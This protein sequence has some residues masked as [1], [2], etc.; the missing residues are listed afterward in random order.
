MTDCR[1]IAGRFVFVLL[2]IPAVV[3]GQSLKAFTWESMGPEGGYL[4]DI[5]QNPVNNDLFAVTYGYPAGV[6]KSTNNG[7]TWQKISEIQNY[8]SYLLIDPQQPA[9]MY[10]S[11][12]GL[13]AS[14]GVWKSTDG[15]VVWVQKG[16][17]G[18]Q[19]NYYNVSE[20]VIDRLDPKKLSVCGYCYNYV[21]T[22][23]NFRTYVAKSTDSG[24]SWS[25][26]EYSNIT[27]EEF[28]AFCVEPDPTDASIMYVGGYTYTPE[29]YA[30]G[31]IFRTTNNG[32]S[33]TNITG[34][35]IQ[36]YVYDIVADMNNAG[37]VFVV[38][39]SGVYRS[40]DKGSTWVRSSGNVYGAKLLCDPKNSSIMYAYNYSLLCFRSTDA[41]MTW[42]SLTTGLSGG[43]TNELLIHPSASNTIFTATRA[44]F[45]RSTDGGQH[46]SSSNRGIVASDVPTL[47]CLPT[48]TKTLYI[49]F[50]YSGLYRTSNALGK[51]APTSVTGITW[52]KMP[53]YSYCEG[54]MHMEVSPTDPNVI[55][56]QEGA[57]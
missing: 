33:W 38:T 37:K 24:D 28:Y 5:A 40:T 4:S 43:I 17:P 45:F 12:S 30:Y 54:I 53:E 34:T 50:M 35:V 20:F 9:T 29:K 19:D 22:T 51:G 23:S 32:T 7:D 26:R 44:G 41:G 57:G 13:Y 18:L 15:G 21:P 31:R 25:I 11:Q 16:F 48:S 52:E 3:N 8:M 36:G 1:A 46:W 47:R 10:A 14:Y 42:T 39:S 56:I 2:L 6:Y 27:S 49:S 55:Y